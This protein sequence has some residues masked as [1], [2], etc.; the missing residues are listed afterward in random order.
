MLIGL[1]TGAQVWGETI[2]VGPIGKAP[3]DGTYLQSYILANSWPWSHKV[4]DIQYQGTDRTVY[5]PYASGA[6]KGYLL[7]PPAPVWDQ[8]RPVAV[9][10]YER[11][12]QEAWWQGQ[13]QRFGHQALRLNPPF[14]ALMILPGFET[15][16]L[17]AELEKQLDKVAYDFIV[18]DAWRGL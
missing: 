16:F 2:N 9:E 8:W 18:K 15:R 6:Y 1:T 14:N 17:A 13:F 11:F 7:N 10:H 12:L 4:V 3:Q 5:A